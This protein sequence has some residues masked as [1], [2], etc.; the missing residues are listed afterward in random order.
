MLAL[1]GTNIRKKYQQSQ[2]SPSPLEWIPSPTKKIFRLAMIEREKVQQGHI[3]DKFI[4]M[5]ISGR[6]D[7]CLHAKSPI[8]LEDIFRNTLNGGDII[9]I[10]GAPGSGKGTLTVHFCQ[11]WGIGELFQQFTVVIFVQ[12]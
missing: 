1:F 8:E 12:L 3:E 4:R 7:D 11:R 10:E 5:T 9:L 6:V 2:G